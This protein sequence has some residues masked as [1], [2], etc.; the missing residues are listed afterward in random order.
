MASRHLSSKNSMVSVVF[1]ITLGLSAS[2]LAEIDG[3]FMIVSG[4]VT[5][6]TKAGA[7]QPARI[8]SQL[9]EGDQVTTGANSRAK[10][11]M[12]DKNVLNISPDSKVIITKY[13]NDANEKNVDLKVEQGKLRSSVEQKYDGNKS[14]FNV[15]TPTAVAGVRG[16]DFI[17]SYDPVS[18]V[19]QFV[20]FHGVVSVAQITNGVLSK[21]VQV[22]G[23]NG[24]LVNPN[25]NAPEIPKAV[26]ASQLQQ[27][28][29]QT[30]AEGAMNRS[31]SASREVASVNA[32]GA[33]TPP[34]SGMVGAQDLSPDVIKNV[35]FIAP[36]V[37][38]AVIAPPPVVNPPLPP[39]STLLQNVTGGSGNARI[40]ITLIPQ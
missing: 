5:L 33:L 12:A 37:G 4:Q 32:K 11:V 34:P 38:T 14:Q 10:I 2:A 6:T 13:R 19:S 15:H 8:G 21:S 27:L 25:A 30:S 36:P 26:P 16:T 9:H 20:T 28:N 23:G 24:T 17:S 29:S 1:F 31:M 35:S 40:N 7:S 3:L 18:H 22:K 39:T